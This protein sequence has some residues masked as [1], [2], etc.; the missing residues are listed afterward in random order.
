MRAARL[1]HG[2]DHGDD[3]LCGVLGPM[4]FLR[5]WQKSRLTEGSCV[6]E[7]CAP[8]CECAAHGRGGRTSI[9]AVGGVQSCGPPS[10]R[11]DLERAAKLAT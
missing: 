10:R 1:H 2:R 6:T 5:K 3:A 9:V 4:L 7:R 8:T 11:V